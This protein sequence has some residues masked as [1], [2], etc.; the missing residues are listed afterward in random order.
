MAAVRTT[1]YISSITRSLLIQGQTDRT[2]VLEG[3]GGRKEGGE[4]ERGEKL[5]DIRDI[6]VI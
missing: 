6:Y 1:R 3:Q 4:G 5:C 2:P